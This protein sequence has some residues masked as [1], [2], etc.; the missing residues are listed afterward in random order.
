MDCGCKAYATG[1]RSLNSSCCFCDSKIFVV[2]IRCP[3]GRFPEDVIQCNGIGWL[4]THIF[5]LACCEGSTKLQEDLRKHG[6]ERGISN[7]V[8]RRYLYFSFYVITRHFCKKTVRT[9][10]CNSCDG[11][12]FERT[13]KISEYPEWTPRLRTFIS[14]SHIGISFRVGI[15]FTAQCAMF[16]NLFHY[17]KRAD[18]IYDSRQ[19]RN[20]VYAHAFYSSR[21]IVYASI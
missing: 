11:R 13:M 7:K 12:I 21:G 16:S 1:Q 8:Y 6:R 10:D 17:G 19:C 15:E 5:S 14:G 9:P 18:K 2:R 20:T 4:I 3:G